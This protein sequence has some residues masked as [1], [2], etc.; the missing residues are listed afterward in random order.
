M[1]EDFSFS[2]EDGKLYLVHLN[3]QRFTIDFDENKNDYSRKSPKGGQELLTKAIA[4]EKKCKTVLDLTA[5]L[6]I[7]AVFLSQNGFQVTALERNPMLYRLLA[8]AVETTTR[9][10]L[11]ELRVI[12]SDSRKFL[13]E[14]PEDH[15][16]QVAYYDTMYPEKK[17]SALPRKEMQLFR[18]LVGPDEDS[19]EVLKLCLEKKFERVLV[20]RPLKAEPIL[21]QVVHSFKG[22]SVR[23]DLY[24]QR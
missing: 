10:E 13:A 11:S 15:L 6:G 4:G 21:P 12:L 8:N 23:Y 18:E 20:K 3:G 14:L 19:E 22:T 5:G 16:Y 2:L 9:Q 1:R 24:I 17:K 7:D